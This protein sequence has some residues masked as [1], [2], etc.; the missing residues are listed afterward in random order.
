MKGLIGKIEISGQIELLTG[1]HIGAGNTFSTI[2]AVDT[3]T[4]RDS[5]SKIPYIPGSSLK[6]KLRFLLAR[7]Y[8]KSGELKDFDEE[9]IKIKRLFGSTTSQ[10]AA[11]LQFMDLKMNEESRSKL[12]KIDTDL[13]YTEIKIENTISRESG[14]AIN[15]RQIERVP[16]T[17]IFDFSIIYNVEDMDEIDEDFKN[18]KT[19]FELL[20]M[21]YLGGHGSRGYGRVKVNNLKA[22]VL[23]G[24]E[25]LSKYNREL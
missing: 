17:A 1:L 12:E 19:M 6:G 23:F 15:L 22:T 3:N 11:R 14:K 8:A 24:N 25:E 2:G 16:R 7:S 13:P 18:I 21:D 4:V 20:E 10:K 9:P 5:V